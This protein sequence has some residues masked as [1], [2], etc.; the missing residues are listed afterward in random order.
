MEPSSQH[1]QQRGRHG[2]RRSRRRWMVL[3]A[4]V[5]LAAAAVSA[6]L[7]TSWLD[8]Y[9]RAEALRTQV[10]ILRDAVNAQ[11][12]AVLASGL[13]AARAAADSLQAGTDGVPW[14]LLGG[15]PVVGGTARALGVLAES[16]A[17]LLGA[18]E[19]LTPYSEQI[20][21][22]GLRREDGAIDVD[23]IAQAAPL[24]ARLSTAAN[25]A[26]ARLGSVDAE[27]IRPEVGVPLAELRDELAG[28]APTL[29]GA[30]EAAARAPALLGA[31]G[32]RTWLVLLQ[33]PAEA[34]GTGGFPGGYVAIAANDGALSV[35]GAGTSSDLNSQP[36]PDAGADPDAREMWGDY[37][38]Q[39]NTANMSPHFPVIGRL[40]ADAMAARGQAVDGVVALDPATVAALLSVTGPVEFAGRVITAENAVDFFTVGV[41]ADYPDKV[42]RDEVT[43]GIV[44]AVLTS[45][46]SAEWDPVDLVDALEGPVSQGRVRAWSADV[47]EEQ[48]LA[49]TSLGGVVPDT[50]GPVIAVAFNNAA[51][52]K[53]DAFVSAAVQY[54]PGTC[55][56]NTR[57]ESALSVTLANDAP[58]VLPADG[59]A[60]GRADDPTAPAGS[61]RLLVHVYAPVGAEFQAATIDGAPATLYAG[62]ER[63]RPVWWTYITLER[64]Q[65]TRIDVQFA[66]P[67]V[68]GPAPEV[69]PQGMVIDEQISI[70]PDPGC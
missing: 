4:V 65:E 10:S 42:E 28:I 25:Q 43:M 48:W 11:E 51:G 31:D 64:G 8:T 46:L 17:G 56:M 30:A 24:L 62:R 19:P 47:A 23:A 68:V 55:P 22:N 57:Q 61:T 18:A 3:A 20:L 67:S 53:M 1:D 49:S 14:R 59:T 66:E 9:R 16:S 60:Y 70:V 50:P 58:A 44:G 7:V 39:W 52:N 33:N 13:P 21:S 27:A 36:I 45:F 6:W 63:N 29:S 69:L 38:T 12:W 5:V 37:L 40:A 2:H 34:R 54:R 35:R 15:V 26:V 32:E 41:Y